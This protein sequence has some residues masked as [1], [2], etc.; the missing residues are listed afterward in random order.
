MS[1]LRFFLFSF[2][3][4]VVA[5][6]LGAA[7]T[8]TA[9]FLGTVMDSSG[10]VLPGAQV[11]ASNIDTGLKR[12]TVS[13][14]EGRFL[15][16]ELPPGSYELTV[17][18]PSFET[19]VRKGLTLTVGQQ[20]SLTLSLKV[21][22]ANEQ[23][24]VTGDA[25]IVE[26]SQSSV[27]GVVEEKRITELPL[28]GRDFTQLAL[29][30][31]STVSLRNTG[32]GEVGRGFGTRMSVAGSRP[33]QTGWLLDGMKIN[34][35]TFFGTPGSAG[36]GLLGVDGVREFQVLTTN[37]SSEFGGT[38]GGVVNMV[39]K[40]GTN[41]FHGTVY[42]FLRNSALD[43]A[44]W[45]DNA[46]GNGKVPFKRNQFGFSVG[47]PIKKDRT[48]FFFNYEGLRQPKGVTNSS[49]VPDANAHNGL[50]PGPNGGLQQVNIA[51]SVAGLLQTWP[52]PNSP[53]NAGP[54]VGYYVSSTSQR[55]T[56]NF[57]MMR[58]DHRL[59][60]SQSIFGRFSFDE[61]SQI[62]P[63][64]IPVDDVKLETH[65]RYGTI[66]LV[67]VWS[68]KLLTTTRAGVSRNNI[69]LNETMNVKYPQSGFFLN[70]N[71]PI[72][73]QI[74]GN[75]L[76]N[77]G[78]DT[79]NIQQTIQNV[80]QVQENISYTSGNHAYKFGVEFE[81]LDPNFNSG[82]NNGGM[83]R[84][85]SL[86]DFLQDNPLQQLSSSLP[87]NDPYRTFRQNLF[88]FYFNDDWKMSSRLTWNLGLRYEPYTAPSEKWGRVSVVKDWLTAT[89]YDTGG[90]MFQ[91]PGNKYFA[92]RVGFAF[93]PKGNGKT[94]IRGG[95]GV[96]YIPLTTTV[97]SRASTRNAPFSGSI[98][99]QP[100][101]ATGKVANFASALAFAN[102]IA[103]QYLTPQFNAT[104]APIMVQ[105]RPDA[106]YEMKANFTV[107]QQIGQD[108]AVS[109]GY[110][111]GR[112]I[113]LTRTANVNMR[114]PTI[115]NGRTFVNGSSPLP[116]R[117]LFQGQLVVTDSQ[118]FYNALRLQLK[119]RLSRNYQYQVSYTWSKSIDDATAGSSNSSYQTEGA[120]S[121]LWNPK[122]D[123]GLSA[124]NQTHN[125]TVN[126][127]WALPSIS[128]NKIVSS[129]LGGWQ[130]TG[131]FT[132]VTGTPFT[133]V[134]SGSNVND[135][136]KPGSGTQLREP[137]WVGGNRSFSSLTSGT[138]A[139]CTFVG[140][141]PGPY[142]AGRP[143]SVAPGQKLGTPNLWFDPC[144][145]AVPPAGFYG[146]A[147]RGILIG[148]GTVDFDAGLG[149]NIPL[150]EEAHLEFRG[151]FFNLF[152]R[153]NYAD[154]ATGVVNAS[155]NSL[156]TTV[157]QVTRTVTSSRQLQFSLKVVF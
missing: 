70:P 92:P 88:G 62:T 153:P 35:N 18:L 103:P 134:L 55:T 113:H 10:A 131:I 41:Q 110:V 122:A 4:L 137:E 63:D 101:D 43:A 142:V 80:Y 100:K 5:A 61:A 14:E 23:V 34:S 127:L 57:Y 151:D 56:E 130:A 71:F 90:T 125:F 156:I 46:Y 47:G 86:S 114:Y 140:G 126:G 96:F 94:A 116:N 64:P 150:K 133:P 139:G 81:K 67:S 143:N 82:P 58:V 27:S 42:E 145:F 25:P 105:Y 8:T 16:S 22:G 60:D 75:G 31:P 120:S 30:E 12:T 111:G 72:E 13:N 152:N 146:T 21:G 149:K 29:V 147:G 144:A 40:S 28:N 117:N 33:D 141:V 118:S 6:P 87:G 112:G 52:K 1:V 48:F 78:P 9:A 3:I 51:P 108:L 79:S 135:N 154:P 129:V 37:Y 36:G 138:T 49:V 107:E 157:G 76:N 89:H 74:P 104:S 69:G 124:L 97:Y 128:A 66:Q 98:Q 68:P 83:L 155:N 24:V 102:S 119:K 54:G 148:P 2:L 77:F 95:F 65:P 106:S 19:L 39:T 26:T 132:M 45:E 11:T 109:V 38:S 136:G 73:I 84:W 53:Q 44:A 115:V 15:L 99:I 7:Q 32:T 121:Q 91:T 59:S 50:I 17:S 123:R 93:D 85:A 20:A